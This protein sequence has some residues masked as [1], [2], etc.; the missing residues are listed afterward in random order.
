LRP[1][2]ARNR[3]SWDLGAAAQLGLGLEYGVQA[4]R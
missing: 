3:Y 2:T 4:T 1:A